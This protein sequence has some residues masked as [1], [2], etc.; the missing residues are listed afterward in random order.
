MKAFI[1]Y[2]ESGRTVEGMFELLEQTENYV[3]IK[4]NDNT[5]I[6]PYHKINKVKLKGGNKDKQYDDD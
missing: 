4:S 1:S 6:I 5:I 2:Q 3:K